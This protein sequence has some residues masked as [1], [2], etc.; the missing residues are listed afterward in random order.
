MKKKFA[1]VNLNLIR[2]N[3]VTV[4]LLFVSNFSNAQFDTAR[5]SVIGGANSDECRQIIELRSGGYIA[6]GTTASFGQGNSDVYV[7]KLDVNGICLWSETIG[8]AG[9]DRGYSV[10][11]T[12]DGG[13]IIAGYTNDYGALGYDMLLVKTDSMGT[14]QWVKTYGGSDWDFGY[15]VQQTADSGFVICG[16]SY[17]FSNG[18]ADV[19]VVK[20]DYSGNVIWQKNT[21]G[22]LS[23]VGYSIVINRSGNYV[24]AGKTFSYGNGNY[25]AYVIMLNS[26]GDTI[27]TKNY[28]G[29]FGSDVAYAI[30]TTS[31]NGFVFAG[32]TDSLGT[33]DID[34]LLIKLDSLGNLLWMQN[35]GGDGNGTMH[36]VI[37]TPLGYIV[38]GTDD[39]FGAGG[40]GFYMTRRDGAG[41]WQAGPTFGGPGDERGYS[42]VKSSDGS[43]MFAGTTTSYGHGFE[44]VYLIKLPSDTIVQEYILDIR[45]CN[46]TP[47]VASVL[48][49]DTEVISPMVY[50]NPFHEWTEISLNFS[51]NKSQNFNFEVYDLLGRNVYSNKNLSAAKFRFRRGNLQSGL[52]Y[53]LVTANNKQLAKGKFI[54]N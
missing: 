4:V 17:G 35:L 6:V 2:K 29:Y 40:F 23:D 46:D 11:E 37:Q 38:G 22:I 52:Y 25:N 26:S 15:S 43:I 49:Y 30:D 34:G 10:K 14:L 48:N 7:I 47:F 12:F 18:D 53:F 42:V 20:T 16:E 39:S 32:V 33:G 1:V 21:G 36:C 41:N 54:V 3:L 27:W 45:I 13:L 24:I 8:E 19:F 31:D 28:D 9:I 44:D 51:T 50:P 5:I